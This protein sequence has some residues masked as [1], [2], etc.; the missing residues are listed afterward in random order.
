MG[1]VPVAVAVSLLTAFAWVL[2]TGAAILLVAHGPAGMTGGLLRLSASG[3]AL[4]LSWGLTC[5]V[6]P[7]LRR[8]FV[9]LPH[10]L[11]FEEPGTFVA[12]AEI[13]VGDGPGARRQ[14]IGVVRRV[15]SPAPEGPP[16]TRDR[17]A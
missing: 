4:F 3:A 15:S 6:V 9:R 12:A 5:L 8:I 10:G 2:G 1:G 7:P 11:R 14:G 16:E 13:G 17:A